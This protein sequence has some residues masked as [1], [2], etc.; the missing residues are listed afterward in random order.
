MTQAALDDGILMRAH[1]N[2][3]AAVSALLYGL[4]FHK[5]AVE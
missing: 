3:Q 1:G 2:A 4:G 5:V